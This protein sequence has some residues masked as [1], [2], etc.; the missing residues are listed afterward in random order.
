MINEILAWNP[1]VQKWLI[2]TF[3][4]KPYLIHLANKLSS[5]SSSLLSSSLWKS[6]FEVLLEAE[7]SDFPETWGRGKWDRGWYDE[8]FESCSALT[9][10][11]GC[12]GSDRIV[13]QLIYRNQL[14]P[15]NKVTRSLHILFFLDFK[16]SSLWLF[17]SVK[18]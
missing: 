2:L 9:R 12:V 14:L 8:P 10:L 18:L 17:L 3:Y 11:T 6:W 13:N 1:Y 16:S 15:F 7:D 4:V 5:S